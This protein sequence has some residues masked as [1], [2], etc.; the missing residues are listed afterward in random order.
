MFLVNG[1]I[2]KEDVQKIYN[3][4]ME[5][6]D[7]DS[8]E[9]AAN[10]ENTVEREVDLSESSVPQQEDNASGSA[11]QLFETQEISL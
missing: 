4:S 10:D 11:T 1:I 6:R 8:R 7:R 2:P 5:F 3:M 9:A